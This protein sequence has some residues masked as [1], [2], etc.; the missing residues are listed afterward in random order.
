MAQQLAGI[1]D[2]VQRITGKTG[3]LLGNDK[4]EAIFCSFIHHAIKVL[5]FLGGDT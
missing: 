1:L 5:S 2:G 4:V 3:N